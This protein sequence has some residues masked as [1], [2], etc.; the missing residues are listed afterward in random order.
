M[1][2]REVLE[3]CHGVLLNTLAAQRSKRNPIVWE[4]N[5]EIHFSRACGSTRWIF[6]LL[7]SY[8]SDAIK[9][10]RARILVSGQIQFS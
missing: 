6:L 3:T 10:W 4:Y 2:P 1:T 7:F 5:E 8:S 9:G